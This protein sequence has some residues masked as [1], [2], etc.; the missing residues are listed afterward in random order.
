MIDP[1]AILKVIS[2]LAV[3]N[4][5]LEAEIEM[6]KAGQRQPPSADRAS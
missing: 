2:D 5:R 3:R 4:A 1:A 6:L